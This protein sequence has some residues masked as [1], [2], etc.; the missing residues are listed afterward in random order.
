MVLGHFGVGLGA[1][2]FAPSL[3]LGLLFMAAQ[4]V[5]LLWPVLLL[6]NVEHVDI[7]KGNPHFPLEF[8]SYPITHSLLM[9]I[10]WGACF[11]LIYYA[12]KKDWKAAI[13]L[14]LCVPSHWLLDLIVHKPDLPLFPGAGPRVGL[15]LWNSPIGTAIVEGGI[16]VIGLVLYLRSTRA[17][18]RQGKWGLWLLVFLLIANQIA[19]ALSPLPPSAHAIGWAAQYQWIFILLG[20]WVDRHRSSLFVK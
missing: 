16:F 1:K 12:I 14:G 13:V 10:V 6:F 17:K 7:N 15:G 8:T 2:K 9:G 18:D 5:D 19:G 4:W 20:F 3:S 11:T